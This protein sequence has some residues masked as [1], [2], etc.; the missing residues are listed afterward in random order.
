MEGR[1][2][3]LEPLD[4]AKHAESLFSANGRDSQGKIWTYLPYGPFGSLAEYRQWMDRTCCGND[5]LFFVIREKPENNATGVASFMRIDRENGSIEIGHV[6]FSPL[7]QRT[8]AATE[9]VFLMINM[10]FALGFRRCEWKCNALNAASRNAAL[11]LGFSFEG[12]F[13]QAAVIKGC[14]RDTAWFSIID[15]EWQSRKSAFE[16][17]LQPSNFDEQGRQRARLS[18]FMP[19]RKQ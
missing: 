6:C 15:P 1:F 4:A 3:R 13:R 7:L 19:G 16:K 17:W 14:N 8:A 12:I 5:P 18:D 10:A 2:C 9:A 11:R